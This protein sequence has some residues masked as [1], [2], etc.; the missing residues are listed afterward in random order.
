MDDL[1]M[2]VVKYAKG[3]GRTG[4]GHYDAAHQSESRNKWL[5]W[6]N[7]SLSAIV[8]TSIFTTYVEKIPILTGAI[9]LAAAAVGA[10]LASSK[11]AEIAAR[12]RVA[13][14]RYGRLRRWADMLKLKIEGNDIE[15]E[16]ALRELEKIGEALSKLAEESL[17]LPDPIYY[18]AKGKFDKDHPEYM[19]KSD[20]SGSHEA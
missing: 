3:A 9:A 10:I 18:P 5:V 7:V 4:L 15:R 20:L 6:L 13:G 16:A 11:L 14:A 2:R 1:I 17:S 12:H 8:G 19:L